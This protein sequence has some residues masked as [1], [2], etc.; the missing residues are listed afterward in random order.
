MGECNIA[1]DYQEMRSPVERLEREQH[2]APV[3]IAKAGATAA[4]RPSAGVEH[5]TP[6]TLRKPETRLHFPPF[7]NALLGWPSDFKFDLSPEAKTW[8]CYRGPLILFTNWDA[9]GSDEFY[10]LFGF[11]PGQISV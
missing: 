10:Q 4:H 2:T 11:L 9:G 1:R 5:H 7:L 6:P 3:C 8:Q